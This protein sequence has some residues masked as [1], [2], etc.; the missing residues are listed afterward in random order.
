MSD[1]QSI[2]QCPCATPG[3]ETCE[4]PPELVTGHLDEVEVAGLE[5]IGIVERCEEKRQCL[6]RCLESIEK[7]GLLAPSK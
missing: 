1:G 5:T 2:V 6:Q 3:N 7:H 4:V